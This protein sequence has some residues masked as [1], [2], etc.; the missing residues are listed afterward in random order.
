MF[1]K[2]R[3]RQTTKYVDPFLV[4]TLKERKLEGIVKDNQVFIIE[5]QNH[6]FHLLDKLPDLTKVW[7]SIDRDFYCISQDE[8]KLQ[9]KIEKFT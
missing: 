9:K 4:N 8:V 7:V 6:S 2:Y 5:G 1:N 3:L